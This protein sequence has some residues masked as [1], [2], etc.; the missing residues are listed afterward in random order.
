VELKTC[1]QNCPITKVVVCVLH[2]GAPT[3]SSGDETSLQ[4]IVTAPVRIWILPDVSCDPNFPVWWRLA[5]FP[6]LMAIG[7]RRR[8]CRWVCKFHAH[9]GWLADLVDRGELPGAGEREKIFRRLVAGR[10]REGLV[11]AWSMGSGEAS[12]VRDVLGKIENGKDVDAAVVNRA[13]GFADI[14]RRRAR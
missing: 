6:Q 3:P 4:A 10:L 13:I 5:A 9:W 2:L 12:F 8:L 11:V 7:R 1:A 14:A